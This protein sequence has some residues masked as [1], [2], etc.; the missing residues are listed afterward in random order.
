MG[1][2]EPDKSLPWYERK[3]H[4]IETIKDLDFRHKAVIC[5]DK[6][7][8]LEDLNRL[9]RTKEN[10]SFDVFNKGYDDQQWYYTSVYNSLV[11]NEDENHPMY[12][13]L[14]KAIENVFGNQ[15]EMFRT[16]NIM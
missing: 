1:A 8:N 13:R 16:K 5:A 4:K 3:K 12:V 11:L 6:I 2:T 14:K 15:D 10:F 9:I 7:N